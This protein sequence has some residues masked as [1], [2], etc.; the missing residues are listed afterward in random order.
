[1]STDVEIAPAFIATHRIIV[2]LGTCGANF[3]ACAGGSEMVA[4]TGCGDGD[5]V[6]VC[7]RS[8]NGTGVIIAGCAGGSSRMTRIVLIGRA[9]R[10]AGG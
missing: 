1:M 9:I 2:Q 8:S 6:V 7:Q 4:G 3:C 10:L 5:C